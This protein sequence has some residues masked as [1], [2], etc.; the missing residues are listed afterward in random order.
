VVRNVAAQALNAVGEGH[1]A[2]L[3]RNVVVVAQRAQADH[4]AAMVRNVVAA[5][6][7]ARADPVCV[8]KAPD[9]L[10]YQR[11]RVCHDVLAASGD[12]KG[13]KGMRLRLKE[14]SPAL[15]R[16][17][18]LAHSARCAPEDPRGELFDGAAQDFA[19]GLEFY[20][21]PDRPRRED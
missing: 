5:A 7:R 19:R 18:A 21:R 14:D 11:A 16:V 10:R 1:C 15:L 13:P 9:V 12:S 8:R 4:C 20:S 3:A 17:H 6:Q 2:A